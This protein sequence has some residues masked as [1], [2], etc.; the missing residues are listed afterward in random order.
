MRKNEPPSLHSTSWPRCPQISTLSL[1]S[2][3]KNASP[4]HPV[5]KRPHTTS[6]PEVILDPSSVSH[7]DP[8][9]PVQLETHLNRYT[10]EQ[11]LSVQVAHK[12]ANSLPDKLALGTVRFLRWSM[13]LVTGYRSTTATSSRTNAMTEKKWI[14]RFIFLESVAGVPGMV[15]GMLRHLKSLRQ[16]K[17]DYGW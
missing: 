17:R 7:H 11:I 3:P 5:Y 10:Q 12:N 6:Y 15:A 1:I 14:T 8:S 13:D 16:M 2:G 4:N 9:N